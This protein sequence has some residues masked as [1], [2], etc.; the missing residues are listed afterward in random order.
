M[1][2]ENGTE[3]PPSNGAQSNG[4]PVN[5]TEEGYLAMNNTT[6]TRPHPLFRADILRALSQNTVKTE[7]GTLRSNLDGVVR[8]LRSEHGANA[9]LADASTV[10]F[11]PEIANELAKKIGFRSSPLGRYEVL[12]AIRRH[13]SRASNGDNV[14]ILDMPAMLTEMKES[15]RSLDFARMSPSVW[16]DALTDEMARRLD[17]CQSVYAGGDYEEVANPPV[18]PEPPPPHECNTTASKQNEED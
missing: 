14:L 18:I 10:D 17:I 4:L 3:E 7:N 15:G 12:C 6:C 9:Y 2:N 5:G 16:P 1:A 13:T 11:H 8:S